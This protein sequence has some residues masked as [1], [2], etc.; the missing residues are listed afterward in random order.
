MK[1]YKVRTVN[2]TIS[3]IF[4]DKNGDFANMSDEDIFQE[5]REELAEQ[6]DFRDLSVSDFDSNFTVKTYEEKEE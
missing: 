1:E 5:A 2:F 4:S 3:Y 6:L